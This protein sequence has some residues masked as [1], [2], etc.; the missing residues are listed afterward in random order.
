VDEVL[1]LLIPIVVPEVL[2]KHRS[3]LGT[4]PVVVGVLATE[5]RMGRVTATTCTD[6]ASVA[7][8]VVM[9]RATIKIT[10]IFDTVVTATTMDTVVTA[11]TMDTVVTATTMVR[12]GVNTTTVTCTIMVRTIAG[13]TTV[14]VIT[15]AI[16]ELATVSLAGGKPSRCTLSA[17]PTCVTK[18]AIVVGARARC[19]GLH[20]VPTDS[21]K[22]QIQSG[23]GR[24]CRA[25]LMPL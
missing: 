20:L 22:V 3:N 25:W 5:D 24:K 23:V 7:H 19:G 17:T 13:S 12:T 6:T 4:L 1:H 14:A 2:A 18:E 8:I 21:L 11:T 15:A 9:T 10:M 16:S